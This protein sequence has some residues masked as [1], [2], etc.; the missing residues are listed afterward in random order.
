MFCT[1]YVIYPMLAWY[2]WHY[3]YR[4]GER[5]ATRVCK[6]SELKFQRYGLHV[7]YIWCIYIY[8]IFTEYE[9]QRVVFF[10]HIHK[11]RSAARVCKFSAQGFS[12]LESGQPSQNQPS[13]NGKAENCTSMKLTK[14]DRQNHTGRPPV[15]IRY[16]I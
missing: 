8:C 4:A 10:C 14:P 9:L 5:S 15:R 3:W 16:H 1:Y 2:M 6:V 12:T 11:E 13:Q 7:C